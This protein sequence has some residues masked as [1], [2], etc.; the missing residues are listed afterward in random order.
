MY[1]QDVFDRK[2]QREILFSLHFLSGICANSGLSSHWEQW[3][4]SPYEPA[5]PH[6]LRDPWW[7]GVHQAPA[8]RTRPPPPPAHSKA[9]EEWTPA[10]QRLRLCEVWWCVSSLPPEL[11]L[12]CDCEQIEP[13]LPYEFTCEGMLQRVNAFI[14]NQVPK[15]KYQTTQIWKTQFGNTIQHVCIKYS[16]KYNKSNHTFKSKL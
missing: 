10:Q 15:L 6:M 13:Y 14:Q 11:C 4:C 3:A 7:A 5:E 2:R 9:E 16:Q 1:L 12:F 8:G